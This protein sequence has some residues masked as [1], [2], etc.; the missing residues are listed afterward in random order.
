MMNIS[1]HYAVLEARTATELVAGIEAALRR[2]DLAP[3]DR[4]PPIRALASTLGLSPTTVAAAYRELR[5]RGI[6]EAAARAGTRIRVHRPRPGQVDITTL[7]PGV[8][9]L[10]SGHPDPALLPVIRPL[11]LSSRLYD[12][13]QVSPDLRSVAQRRLADDG[14]DAAHLAVVHGALDGVER[15]L[16]SWLAP[17]SPVAVED[18]GYAPAL[19]LIADLGMRAVPVAVDDRGILPGALRTALAA[20]IDAVLVTPRAQ[21][22]TGA[23][24]DAERCAEI[25]GVLAGH[26]SVALIE[27]DH[28]GPVAGVPLRT[29]SGTTERWAHIRSVSK[30]LAPDLRTA[31]IVGDDTTIAAVADH[32]A[33]GCG[34]VSHT[35]QHAV[36]AAW[37]DPSVEELMVRA[38]ATYR[39]RREQL[40]G[41]LDAV[42]ITV[43]GRSGL[44]TWVPVADEVGVVSGLL[45]AGWAV[46]AGA[47]FRLGS[48]SAVRV[49]HG[50]LEGADA[51]RF[52]DALGTVVAGHPTHLA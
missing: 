16:A 39:R 48:P 12:R 3:G 19:A 6:T 14:V 44:T 17:G 40:A 21:N 25:R 33:I 20:G 22:P 32:Q 30:W 52:A 2:G 4:L 47:R 9:D 49:G 23:A 45:A 13:P 11:T 36:A 7:P 38:S 50:T 8:R 51:V 26:P 43:T 18:P 37:S 35:L 31:I 34:W 29:A 42:G 28:A 24:W 27:D 41:A 5:R 15:V 46:T 1:L 10:R